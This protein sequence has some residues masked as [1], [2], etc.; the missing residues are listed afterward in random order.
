[1]TDTDTDTVTVDG[2]T[3]QVADD[4]GDAGMIA[5]GMTV[6]ADETVSTG[7][8]ESFDA[9]Q[10]T[11]VRIDPAIALDDPEG[12]RAL[13]SMARTLHSDI[14]DDLDHAIGNRLSDPSF[15]DWPDVDPRERDATDDTTDI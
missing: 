9:Y 3:V 11:K 1:M 12:R 10:S 13:R 5:V 6:S 2:T 14:Q 15:E 8:Y 4:P 7:D